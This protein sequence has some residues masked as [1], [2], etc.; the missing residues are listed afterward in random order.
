MSDDKEGKNVT[1]QPPVH[2]DRDANQ[3]AERNDFR[4]GE[5]RKVIKLMREDPWP[6]PPEK[7]SE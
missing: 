6:P 2:D 3:E 4:D 7:D 5:S 1:Q